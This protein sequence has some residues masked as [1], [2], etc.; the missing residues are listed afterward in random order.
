MNS[1]RYHKAFQ[2]WELSE[3]QLRAALKCLEENK[4]KVLVNIIDG[5]LSLGWTDKE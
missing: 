4:G 5:R 2:G 1:I 3:E